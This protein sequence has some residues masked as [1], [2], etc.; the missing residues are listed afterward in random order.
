MSQLFG[1]ACDRCRT[2]LWVGQRGTK[3]IEPWLYSGRTSVAVLTRFLNTH[4]GHP[5]VYSD[6]KVL[7]GY[8][9]VPG[10]SAVGVRPEEGEQREQEKT[11]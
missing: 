8:E 4:H 10:V 2:Y 11:L 6:I 7:E 3:S 1:L 9:E 5:L